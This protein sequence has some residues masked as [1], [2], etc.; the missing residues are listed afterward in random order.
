[1][2]DV[3]TQSYTSTARK[4][5]QPRDRREQKH[6]QDYNKDRLGALDLAAC[7][8]GDLSPRQ[9][10]LYM[11]SSPPLAPMAACPTDTVL[12]PAQRTY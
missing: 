12:S 3:Q 7:L 10:S 11:A 6:E 1:M 4:Q 5:G 2:Q 9:H 8:C